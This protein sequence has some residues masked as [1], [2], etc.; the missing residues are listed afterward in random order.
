MK[1]VLWSGKTSST[2]LKG[3]L[4]SIR[5][6]KV[7]RVFLRMSKKNPSICVINRKLLSGKM[8]SELRKIMDSGAEIHKGA[9][10]D[11]WSQWIRMLLKKIQSREPESA[12]GEKSKIRLRP[13][14]S[15]I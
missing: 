3:P 13:A 6:R 10:K 15:T 12:S 5:W 4:S 14:I 8:T 11:P 1:M 2:Q 9:G 7:A